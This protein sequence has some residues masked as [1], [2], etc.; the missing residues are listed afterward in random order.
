MN[1]AGLTCLELSNGQDIPIQNGIT[2]A[3]VA[4]VKATHAQA[5]IINLVQRHGLTVFDYAEQGQR[6]GLGPDPNSPDY[7]YIALSAVAT[8]DGATIP[9]SAP[10]P[11]SMV[12]SSH[13][14]RAWRCVNGPLPPP[15]APSAWPIALGVVAAVGVAGAVWYLWGRS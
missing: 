5:A 12:D 9:W 8:K 15:P 1:T 7:R 10:W 6:A 3:V 11:A 2:Y 14:V 4:S 13:I